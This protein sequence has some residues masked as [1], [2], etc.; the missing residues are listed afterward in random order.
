LQP[1][2]T[3]LATLHAKNNFSLAIVAGNLFSE[4][5]DTISDLLAERITIPLPTYFTVGTSPLPERII[6]KLEKD[7]EVVI[8]SL[9]TFKV[10]LFTNHHIRFVQTST[11][12]GSAVLQRLPRVSE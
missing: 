3:K 11:F 1:V 10:K 6:Q 7:E 5:N 12:S 8:S 9:F 4:D 2:F